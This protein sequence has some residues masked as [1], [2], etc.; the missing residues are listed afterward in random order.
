ME[1]TNPDSV[2][3]ILDYTVIDI[4]IVFINHRGMNNAKGRRKIFRDECFRFRLRR[5]TK[6]GGRGKPILEQIIFAQTA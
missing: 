4:R 5:I 1:I 6:V 3:L 2:I